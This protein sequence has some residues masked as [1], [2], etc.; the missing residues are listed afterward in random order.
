MTLQPTDT[1]H[2][3]VRCQGGVR[4]G[5]FDIN[6]VL[7]GRLDSKFDFPGSIQGT[8]VPF[9]SG[10]VDS[11]G[12]V[13]TFDAK[14]RRSSLVLGNP[15][16]GWTDSGIFLEVFRADS[17]GFTGRW[18]DGGLVVAIGQRGEPTHAQGHFCATRVRER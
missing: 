5:N 1:L 16:L 18:V 9:S 10:S 14:T 12:V 7:F 15:F 6:H 4:C 2:R 13:L 11:P 3:Y 8:P 17:M